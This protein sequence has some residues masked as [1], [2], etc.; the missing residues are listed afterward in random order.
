MDLTEGYLRAAAQ[1]PDG[2]RIF[3]RT[4]PDRAKDEAMAAHDRAKAGL[5]RGLLDGVSLSWKDNVDSAGVATEGGSRLLE[6]RVP[7]AGRRACWHMRRCR[8]W[9]AWARRT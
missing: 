3:A 1:H 2:A 5:R 9:C 4:T 7:G 6:G 8:G